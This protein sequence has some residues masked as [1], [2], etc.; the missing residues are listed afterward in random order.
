MRTLPAGQYLPG[1]SFLH[2][3]DARAKMLCLFFLIAAVI[4]A[5][6]LWGYAL[7]VAVIAIL[8]LFSGLPLRYAVAPARSMY[9]FLLVI[10]LMNAFFFDGEDAL[11]SWGIFQLSRGGMGQGFRVVSN[12]VLV[13][14]LGNLLTMTTLPTQVTTAL[15]SLIKPLA[16]VGV[17][18]EEVAMIISVAFQFIPTLLEESELIKMAQIAR[19]ARFESKKLSER[20]AS[21]LPLVV[22]I[23]ISAFRRAEELALAMEAR[24]Y[25]NAKNRTQ[26]QK[27]PLVLADYGA[28]VVCALICL[29]Q[30]LLRW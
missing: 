4:G 23:F 24:G 12:V 19:G 27:E 16:L 18:T 26:R 1:H 20:A 13:L 21:F 3:L 30:F 25:R 6:S 10:W 5:S 28:L 2:R 22:P 8:I 11:V 17:P 15:A 9:L 7:V 29:V 14:I